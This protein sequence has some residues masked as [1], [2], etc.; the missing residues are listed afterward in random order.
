MSAPDAGPRRLELPFT[1]R[2]GGLLVPPAAPAP[3]PPLLVALHGQGE[4]G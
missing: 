4:S 1:T 3:R 2:R